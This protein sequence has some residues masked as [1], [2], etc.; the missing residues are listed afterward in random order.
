MP[1][2][3]VIDFVIV[4][5]VGA[6]NLSCPSCY[7][8]NGLA[9]EYRD[10]LSL[11]TARILFEKLVTYIRAH[12]GDRVALCWHGGEPTLVGKQWYRDVLQEQEAIFGGAGV[13]VRNYLQTNATQI[14]AEWAELF[15]RHDFQVG[16]SIDGLPE[17]HDR[18]RPMHNGRGSYEAVIAG[19][20]HLQAAGLKPGSITVI[21]PAHDG[22]AIVRH[23]YNL[24][25]RGID[26]N[27]PIETRH[28]HARRLGP[29]PEAYAHYMCA[30]FDAWVELD[31][32]TFRI[33]SLESLI[34][35]LCGGQSIYCQSGNHC[36]RYL[37]VEPNG[38]V[39]LCEN[40][41]VVDPE[42]EQHSDLLQLTVNTPTGHSGHST[43]YNTQRNI[44]EHSFEEI[45]QVVTQRFNRWGINRRGDI[46]R[47]CSVADVCHSGC[48]VHRYD[49]DTGFANPSFFCTYYKM[50]ISHLSQ[51]L[52]AP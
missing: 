51:R 18:S 1:S 34:R 32:P 44:L 50:L 2:P 42:S 14:D 5:V 41:R 22:A 8:M 17:S 31:D 15:R 20:R 24:G 43:I 11:S 25:L 46:C 16:T 6:C 36:D 19:I 38:A 21:D 27:L 48:P 7:Y 33:R 26:F 45:A 10:R 4:K 9:D 40:L 30:V 12:G 35:L 37:T 52:N 29:P 23:H 28:A 39:G 3:V 13:R 49:K 47:S